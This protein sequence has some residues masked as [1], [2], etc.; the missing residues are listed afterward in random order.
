[1]KNNH[2]KKE[3]AISVLKAIFSAS[4]VK[5]FEKIRGV[6]LCGLPGCG[7]STIAE[8]LHDAYGFE[9]LSTDQVRTEDLFKGQNHRMASEH[10]K[11]MLTRYAVYAKLG[12]MV[13]KKLN[14]KKKV[15]VDGTHLDDKRFSNIGGMLAKIPSNKMAII[16][17]RTPEWI[18]KKRFMDW[19]KEKYDEWWSVYKFW[20]DYI[21]AGK[22]QFPTKK[23][24]SNLQII[25]P[26]C[27]AIRTFDWVTDIKAIGWDLDGT[28]Y[29]P[30][31]IPKKMFTRRQIKAVMEKNCWSKSKAIKEYDRAY[32]KIGSHTKTLLSLGV[33]GV[34]L[35]L[36]IWDELPLDKYLKKDKKLQK[37]FRALGKVRHFILSNG[38]TEKQIKRKLKLLGLN[39]NKFEIISSGY[40]LGLVK[41]DKKVFKVMAEKMKLESEEI[42]YVGDREKADVI[43]ANKIGMK[44]CLV[45]GKSK[46]AD[47]CLKNVYEVAGLF[48]KEV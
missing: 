43:G 45:Y 47:V 18:I 26:K 31:L 46:E 30:N 40:D 27:Y 42:L 19:D 9:I 24:L 16:V 25:K 6:I 44:T 33:D 28:L 41:P 13:N 1:M 34:S 12:V 15:V 32:E 35:F 23:E 7:K 3:I 4:D 8:L 14:D 2:T 36:R 39:L 22:A 5:K 48:G 20:I 29:H 11:V 37:M 17:V 21:K 10:M 38:G